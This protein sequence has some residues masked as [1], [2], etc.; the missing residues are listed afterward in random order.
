MFDFFLLTPPHHHLFLDKVSLYSHA[1]P[2]AY[3]ID[4]SGFELS[5]IHLPLPP[6]V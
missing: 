6:V 5:A 1:W 4:Q 2:R 3:Y